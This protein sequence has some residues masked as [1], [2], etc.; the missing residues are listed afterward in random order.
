VATGWTAGGEAQEA[1]ARISDSEARAICDFAQTLAGEEQVD[2]LLRTLVAWAT[3]RLGL[4]G[5]A[6][7]LPDAEGQ[8]RRRAGAGTLLAMADGEGLDEA[9]GV[10]LPLLVGDQPLGTLW[11][12]GAG[13]TGRDLPVSDAF[14]ALLAQQV[15]FA[16]ERAQLRAQARDAE[17]LR[18]NNELGTRLMVTASHELR[19]PL[20][21]LEVATTLLEQREMARKP[22]VVRMMAATMTREV[23]YLHELLSDLLDLSRI[24]AGALRLNLGWYDVAELVYEATSHL[25]ATLTGSAVEIEATAEIPPVRGDYLLLERVIVNLVAN[26]SRRALPGRPVRV[27]ISQRAESVEV[28][29]ADDG[30]GLRASDGVSQERLRRDESGVRDIGLGLA[31]A[32]VEAHGG[33]VWVESPLA[34]DSG[35]AIHFTLPIG[36]PALDLRAG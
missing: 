9:H 11:M 2:P 31:K 30:P 4:A 1:T 21:V 22:S 29:V 18:R 16:I 25:T 26:A 35:T 28:V 32:I 15:G 8:P 19:T 27:V 24:E 13:P 7:L 3:D 5:C 10:R 14:Q 36:E 34:S 6:V 12:I 23:R 33:K 17:V 20:A